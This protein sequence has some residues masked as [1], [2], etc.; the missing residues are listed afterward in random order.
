MKNRRNEERFSS[1]RLF[2]RSSLSEVI[3]YKL[4]SNN[5]KQ[6]QKIGEFI[7]SQLKKG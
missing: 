3:M 2:F 1:C 5:E 7:G 6:T 4:I